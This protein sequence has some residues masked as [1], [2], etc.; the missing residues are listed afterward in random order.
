VGSV[1]YLINQYPSP[2][3]TFI[4]REI[5]A[6]EAAGSKIVRVS[7][8][9]SR[10]DVVDRDDILEKDKTQ[11][12]L[13]SKFKLAAALC[14]IILT[15]P[16]TFLS[17]FA[18]AISLSRRN[19][20]K[21]F[22]PF[23]YLAEACVLS[24]IVERS[25]VSHIHAHFGTNPAA[26]AMLASILTGCRFSFT[27][28]GPDEFDAPR[29]FALD[30]KARKANNIVAISSYTKS[31]L[32]R[33]LDPA[34]WSK[35]AVV[36]CGL[37]RHYIE[38]L[39]STPP[40]GSTFVSVARL[41]PQKGQ[42]TLLRALNRVVA[43]DPA[44]RLML[45]GGGELLE[46][47]KAEITKLGLTEAVILAGWL[48]GDQVRESILQS[49]AM[50]LSSY[51]EGL[52]IALMEAMAMQR[53]VVA[54]A[55]AGIPELLRDR[56]TGWIVPAGDEQSLADAMID[57]LRTTDEQLAQMGQVARAACIQH[58]DI[59]NNIRELVRIFE[60]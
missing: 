14:R 59:G 36:R 58:H 25:G 55:I 20:N 39:P 50:V 34:D 35:I 5:S 53:P 1:L 31:Q 10:T 47:L 18:A 41:S 38:N 22:H 49:R 60:V 48:D 46:L 23:I 54:T 15:R 2:S 28:H 44:A 9:R 30:L 52:P 57:C 7:V 3:L 29:Q 32:C 37:D 56:E 42:L 16:R 6:L 13:E 17:A 33:W 26:V 11:T 21:A 4:R 45:V 40:T 51:A 43:F 27:V 24:K 12:L 19:V 8:R